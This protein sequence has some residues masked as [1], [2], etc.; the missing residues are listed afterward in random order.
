MSRSS[1]KGYYVDQKLLEKIRNSSVLNS[2]ESS[3]SQP[4][5]G[6]IKKKDKKNQPLAQG[7]FRTWSRSSS[8]HPEMIGRTLLIHNGKEHKEVRIT[9][10]MVGLKLGA[11]APTRKR[12][13]HGKAGK[14]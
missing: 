14:R 3:Q 1:S 13:I 9:S 12:G 10:E 2:P 7:S 6:N 8:V 11:L 4:V 5:K